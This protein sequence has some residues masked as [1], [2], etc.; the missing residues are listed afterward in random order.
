MEPGSS[1]SSSYTSGTSSVPLIGRTIGADLEAT[2]ARVPDREA[3]VVPFQD[4]RLTYA[5]FDA[6]VDEIARGLLALDLVPGDRLGIW[7][8]NCLEWALVQYATAKLGV[9]L[10]NLNPA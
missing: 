8:P 7:S 5:Q 1:P 10:V 6:A 2:V 4:V 3:I 9:I